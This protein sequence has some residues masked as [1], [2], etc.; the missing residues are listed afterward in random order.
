MGLAGP[1]LPGDWQYQEKVEPLVE[2]AVVSLAAWHP[3]YPDRIWRLPPP[4]PAGLTR[5]PFPYAPVDR[6]FA[7]GDFPAFVR[8]KP[9]AVARQPFSSV[10]NLDP[11]QDPTPPV[12]LIVDDLIL[13]GVL[14]GIAGG[15]DA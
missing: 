1:L 12:T 4:T 6:L 14:Y 10:Q 8:G 13:L 11:I 2:S 9:Y 3:I 15:W 5:E 7:W